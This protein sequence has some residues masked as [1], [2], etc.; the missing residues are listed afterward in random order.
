[1]PAQATIPSFF[2]VTV[3][4]SDGVQMR[5]NARSVSGQNAS[6]PFSI[7]SGHANF[8]SLIQGGVTITLDTGAVQNIAHNTGVLRFKNNALEVFVGFDL[9]DLPLA[10][11]AERI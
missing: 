7:L 5:S 3:L 8:I 11:V 1:M 4:S 6:G 10:A 9:A 2:P